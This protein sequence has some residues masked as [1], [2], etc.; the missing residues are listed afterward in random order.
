[1]WLLTLKSVLLATDLGE[2]SLPATR[3][4]V[5]L[6]TLAGATLHLV[7]VTDSPVE[8]GEGGCWSTWREWSRAPEPGSAQLLRGPGDRRDR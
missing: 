3:T 7:H 8:E 2:A 1:M 6:A 5:R 4:A